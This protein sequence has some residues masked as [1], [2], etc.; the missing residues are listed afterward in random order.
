MVG[1]MQE[2]EI[3]HITIDRSEVLNALDVATLK[4][5]HQQLKECRAKVV[6]ITGGGEKAFVSG[7]DI[8][9]MHGMTGEE[10]RFFFEL[11]NEVAH[12]LETGP[13]V[14]IA[15]LNGYAFG[16]GLE[17]A[18]AC[19]IIVASESAKVGLPEVKLGMIPSFGG[20]RRL[21][22]AVGKYKAN[23]LIMTGQ[24]LSAEEAKELG[25]VTH[26][27]PPEQL[28]EE[29]ETLAKSILANSF[30]AVIAAKKLGND[31]DANEW[32]SAKMC[33]D[34]EERKERMRVFLE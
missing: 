29:C 14:T 32:E 26:V 21:H 17:L 28:I 27:V 19:D 11:G 3:V 5:L 7:A 15:A 34:Q 31:S 24:T 10:W 13:F 4:R 8:K 22:R 2:K 9:E 18:L 23:E 1:I 25:V 16:G 33:F 30:T 12:L 6:I 20:V